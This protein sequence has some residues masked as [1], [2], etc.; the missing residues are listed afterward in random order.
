MSTIISLFL[1]NLPSLIAGGESL[2]SYISGMK[3]AL[4]QTA[5]WTDVQDAQWQQ[6][7]IAAGKDPEWLS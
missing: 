5:E 3:S 4:S 2:V 7:L 6:Q 1:A